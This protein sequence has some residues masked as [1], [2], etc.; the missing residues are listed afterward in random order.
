V[1]VAGTPQPILD[2]LNRDI[3]AALR[4]PEVRARIE[5]IGFDVIPSTPQ[6]LTA[7]IRRD[8]EIYAPLIKSGRVRAD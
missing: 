6:E 7:L 5:A 8:A 3:V 2:Q 1:T 4:L